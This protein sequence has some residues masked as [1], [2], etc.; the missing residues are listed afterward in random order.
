M[1][2]FVAFTVFVSLSMLSDNSQVL[3]RHAR[4]VPKVL[5][6]QLL[7]RLTEQFTSTSEVGTKGVISAST[8]MP[9]GTEPSIL[10]F[11]G[12]LLFVDISGFTA[13]SQRLP[14]DELR[15]H[16][17]AYFKSIL[18]IVHDFGGDVI[19]FAGDALYAIW[20]E[21]D[22]NL[23]ECV[24][25]ALSC[26]V[27]IVLK[28]SNFK[29]SFSDRD[30][31]GSQLSN[32]LLSETGNSDVIGE[33][34]LPEAD[35][36]ILDVHAGLSVGTMAGVDVGAH[37]RWE[38]FIVGSPLQDV[39]AAESEASK[40]ELVA[41]AAA[42]SFFCGPTKA[43]DAAAGST[44]ACCCTPTAGGAYKIDIHNPNHLCK[45]VSTQREEDKDELDVEFEQLS[46]VLEGA[47][48][49]FE[50]AKELILAAY[51]HAKSM[52][53][54]V[55]AQSSPRTGGFGNIS[56]GEAEALFSYFLQWIEGCLTDDIWRH[57]HEAIRGDYTLYAAPRRD[58]ILDWFS[59]RGRDSSI[60]RAS[61]VSTDSD[62]SRR[63][64]VSSNGGNGL[65]KR[66][67]GI[68]AN[69]DVLRERRQAR[70][71]HTR[72]NDSALLGELR[73]V[74]VMFINIF[75]ESQGL[76]MDD[77]G[78]REVSCVLKEF[79]F[80]PTT[81]AERNADEELLRRYQ[82]CLE[83]I[84]GALR[85][86]GGQLRQFIV[87][88]KG[89]VCI[90]TFGLRGSVNHDNAAASIEAA[91][92]I[93]FSLRE[94]GISAAIGITSGKAYCGLVGSL[95]RHEY[96]VMG[97]STNLSARLMS[98][99][100]PGQIICDINIRKGDRLHQF[101][102]LGDVKAKG[103]VQLVPTFKPVFVRGSIFSIDGTV[104]LHRQ[105][106]NV[107]QEGGHPLQTPLLSRETTEHAP[108]QRRSKSPKVVGRDVIQRD[109][110]LFLMR[111][112]VDCDVTAEMLSGGVDS[113]LESPC[114]LRLMQTQ[115]VGLR[116][117]F[118][119]RMAVIEGPSGM[120]KS[121]IL[122]LFHDTI[123]G[124]IEA[125]ALNAVIHRSS[126]TNI[127]TMD[128]FKCWKPVVRSLLS[129][130]A[131]NEGQIA[132][133]Q[134]TSAPSKW[135]QGLDTLRSSL[136][137]D[138]R[139]WL[140]LLSLMNIIPGLSDAKPPIELNGAEK[141]KKL[142]TLLFEMLVLFPQKTN[143]VVMLMM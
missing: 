26:G 63:S 3:L 28:C 120:G 64:S 143:K 46:F 102:H 128:P 139:S 78:H 55:N 23:Q 137:P 117:D 4:H 18:D 140:S 24:R 125:N 59:L 25:E 105:P 96:A 94:H 73:N 61:T 38:Y 85:E 15:I 12:A 36:A 121:A 97:P 69:V 19:K 108:K 93:I 77:G 54:E 135:L 98:S 57:T 76:F 88:D 11:D 101:R 104:Q 32:I 87:D 40:G 65:V 91:H 124:N 109:I 115:K 6:Q 141:I 68:S 16:I 123:K 129:D 111:P 48:G 95:R 49:S 114:I 41:S 90:G 44:L 35:Y 133:L 86:K 39:A 122:Q 103:Y 74:I 142:M 5:S 66:S 134:I 34:D 75:T 58:V 116:N 29:V 99:A 112:M 107:A 138:S 126:T 20:K 100:R 132:Q 17:N 47:H 136:S 84:V 82:M 50:R 13:L 52:N 70:H 8:F 106:S 30:K 42:H 110:A 7:S 51:S 62:Q 10:R 37:D 60:T 45:R 22:G 80:K 71:E 21:E 67:R 31:G 92:S 131:D 33:V 79:S 119:T 1:V 130:L 81:M 118:L 89:T 127:N 2:Y 56:G 27:E 14:V 113:Q 9:R 43:D 72:S 83:S 53:T